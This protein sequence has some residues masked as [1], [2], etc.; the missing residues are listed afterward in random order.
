MKYS[1]VHVLG[2][3]QIGD[4]IYTT[5]EYC[6]IRCIISYLTYYL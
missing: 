2:E 4:K 1:P 5:Q 3:Q 6:D